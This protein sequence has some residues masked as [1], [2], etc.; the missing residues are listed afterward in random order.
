MLHANADHAV[1]RAEFNRLKAEG[2]RQA[3]A[4]I[5]LNRDFPFWTRPLNDTNRW[6]APQPHHQVVEDPNAPGRTLELWPEKQMFATGDPIVVHARVVEG[7]VAVAIPRLEAFTESPPR[8]ARPVLDLELR[9]D[10]GGGD[11]I[12]GDFVYSAMVPLDR[13]PAREQ[14]GA[15]G[16]RVRAHFGGMP[17]ETTNQFV[18]WP[19]GATLGGRYRDQIDDG[20]LVIHCAVRAAEPT[21]IQVRGE[22]HGPG[23]EEIAFAWVNA[24]IPEGTTDVPLRFWGKAIHDRGVDGPYQLRNVVLGYPRGRLIGPEA[25][26]LA[27]VTARYAAAQ[28]RSD[29][30]NADNPM[31]GEQISEYEQ[32]L[33]KAERGELEPGPGEP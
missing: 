18:V 6:R 30:Y 19:G 16:Y 21:E 24:T 11:A 4:G 15:W 32:V 10:G 31:F 12:A 13:L 7:G 8:L 33:A 22:L 14:A 5:V 23:G 29:G 20:S 1:E 27:H 17:L 26:A 28:F 25:V 3:L 2:A 9:D